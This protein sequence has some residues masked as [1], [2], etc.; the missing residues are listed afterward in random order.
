VIVPGA[1]VTPLTP[2][3]VG[4]Q[5]S[6]SPAKGT[7]SPVLRLTT[8]LAQ[9]DEEAFRK[10]HAAY[11]DRLL[12]YLFVVMRGDEEAARDALQETFT[13]VARHARPFDCE[14]TF[15]SWLTVLA[16]SAAADAGRKRRSYWRLLTS[17]ALSW[18]PSQ[19]LANETEQ[20]DEHLQALLLEGLSELRGED[21]VLIEAKY[22][23]GAT[24][25]ELAAQTK[26]TEKAIE[27]RLA[28]ARRQL[29][30]HLFRRLKN[31]EAS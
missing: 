10:F 31:E 21:R 20:A 30:Q 6:E 2:G 1:I 16:R 5:M 26:V 14:E 23:R 12:R 25:R 8:E 4:R 9:G 24:V 17:Y 11:F 3:A 28:R 27:S 19:A 22:F 15:W 29:R 7:A 18:M 13:R